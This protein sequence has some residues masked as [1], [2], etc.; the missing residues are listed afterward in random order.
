RQPGWEYGRA[1][2]SAGAGRH[3][4][5]GWWCKV[6]TVPRP[7]YGQQAVARF[8]LSVARKSPRPLTYTP[9]EINGDPAILV[10]DESRL[11]GVLSL[12]LSDAGIQD[13][14][15]LLNPEKLSYLQKQLAA[16]K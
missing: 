8:W 15:A 7:I 5:G 4:L 6:Q 3:H 12:T 10:W 13:I 11:A 16:R 1:D 9:D 14:Y 2:Q